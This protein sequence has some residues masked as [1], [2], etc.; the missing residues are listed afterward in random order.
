MSAIAGILHF[1]GAPLEPS[2]IEKLSGAMKR[3]GPDAQTRWVQGPVALG[4]CMLRATP[5][6]LEEHQPLAS[7]DKNLVM[8]WDGRLDNREELQRQLNA[9]GAVLRDR[10]DAELALQAYAAW[11][12]DCPGRLLGDFAFAVWDA[13]RQCL[14]CA[15]DH[16]GARPFYYV[17]NKRFFAFASEEEAL[18]ELPGVSRQPNE[19]M[20]L[21]ML[22][23][24]YQS[25]DNQRFWLKD[26]WGLQPGQCM[27]VAAD[28]THRSETYWRLEPG[29]E[30]AYAS[31]QACEEAFLDVFGEAV[32]CRMRASGD[33]AAMMSGG[34]DSA[35]IAAM[36]KRLLPGMPGKAFHTYSAIADQPASCVESR[37]IQS[38]TRDSGGNAH[39]VS[40][41]SFTGMADVDDLLETAWARPHPCDN[42]IVLPAMMCLAASRRGQRVMLHGASG[43]L[44]MHVPNRYAAYLLRAGQLHAA[45]RA[46]R[47]ASQNNTYLRGTSPGWL[48]LQN[49]WTAWMPAGIKF[50]LRRLRR[51]N[52]LAGSVVH[53]GFAE[54]LHLTERL[55][56]QE[57]EARRP[58]S[59]NLQQ[60][61]AQAFNAAWGPV[62]GLS[63]YERVAG[64]Y[65]VELRDPW[66]DRRVAEFFLRLPLEY[67]VRDGWNKS[68][69]RSAFAADLEDSVRWRLGKEHLGWQFTVRLMEETDALVEP[70]LELGLE[71]AREYIDAA[72]VRARLKKYRISR[73]I[74]GQEFFYEVLT[75][76]LWVRRVAGG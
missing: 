2:L 3:R 17:L 20:I 74:E 30:R 72:T 64:R 60:D 1:H 29:D 24:A 35:G 61:H 51:G 19:A 15:L 68:L 39:F 16:M 75:L 21:H 50:L 13:R 37:C 32:R 6:S 44:A 47:S 11:G 73:D 14:F 12:E 38:L 41:P 26:V 31:D 59:A 55:R 43:D 22:V 58:F 53:P 49:A 34:M 25:A 62:L 76:M 9:A 71:A 18:L 67:K 42:S 63:G 4:H 48:L 66:A 70:L 65:G 27:S 69:A 46:C 57:A 52:P 23:P 10:S 45:W 28:G 8:V 7:R 36:V 40:V 56:A 33:I 54:K 5:E